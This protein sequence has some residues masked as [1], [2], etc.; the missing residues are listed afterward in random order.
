MKLHLRCYMD[1]CFNGT[2]EIPNK[3]DLKEAFE[4]A[5]EHMDELKIDAS[6]LS[7]IPGSETLDPYDTMCMTKD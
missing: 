5:T 4:Y 7:I 3:M 2:L 6:S 1:A